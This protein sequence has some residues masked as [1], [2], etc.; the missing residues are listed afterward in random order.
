MREI[1][2]LKGT[3]HR[4]LF[5]N[6]DGN[7]NLG[8]FFNDPEIEMGDI[9]W[10]NILAKEMNNS[11]ALKEGLVSIDRKLNEMNEL[12]LS[13]YVELHRNGTSEFQN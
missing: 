4:V 13:C 2:A 8:V 12:T 5:Q 10:Y 6:G 3:R 11:L 9:H 1:V 7:I